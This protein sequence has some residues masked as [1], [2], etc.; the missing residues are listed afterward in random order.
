MIEAVV[1]WILASGCILSALA[2]VVPPFGRNPVHGAMGLIACFF[3]LSGLYVLLAAHL[4]AA[5]QVIVYAGAIMVLFTFVIMLLNLNDDE[6]G[7]PR[8]TAAKAVGILAVGFVFAKSLRV[9]GDSIPTTLM[10]DISTRAPE[11]LDGYGGI[12]GVGLVLLR[13]FLLPFEM[14]SLLL[15]V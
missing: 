12:R 10:A 6:L 15:L 7:E 4:I 2:V 9:L 3:C 11:L 8:Y 1:F 5:L 13:D 14:T